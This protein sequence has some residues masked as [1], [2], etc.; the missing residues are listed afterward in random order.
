LIEIGEQAQ[1]SEFIDESIP[2][3]ARDRTKLGRTIRD[4]R[5][6]PRLILVERTL[7]WIAGLAS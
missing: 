6:G 1:S 3:G 5:V 2:L 4:V 7:P